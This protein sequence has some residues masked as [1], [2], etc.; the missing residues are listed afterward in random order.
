[1]RCSGGRLARPC[2]LIASALLTLSPGRL[3]AQRA[4]SPALVEL[5]SDS[6]IASYLREIFLARLRR[7]RERSRCEESPIVN[8]DSSAPE[9]RGA[10]LRGRVHSPSNGSGEGI[11]GAQ[12]SVAPLNLGSSTDANGS[13]ELRV[14]PEALAV[15][16]SVTVVARHIGYMAVSIPLVLRRGMVVKLDL[17]LCFQQTHLYEAVVSPSPYEGRSV[18]NDQVSGVDE[19]GIVK[20]H[21]DHLVI[22]HRGRIFT[23]DVSRGHLRRVDM[24]SAPGPGISGRD[25]WYDELL[26]SGDKVV[27]IGYSYRRGGVEIGV[28]S[29]SDSGKLQYLD[30]YNLRSNDYYSSRN[31]SSRLIGS[32]LVIYSPLY[33]TADTAH[34]LEML[35]SMRRWRPDAVLVD[36]GSRVEGEFHPVA[37]ELHT[38]KPAGHVDLSSLQALHSVTTCD[39]AAPEL[40]CE[41]S[42]FVGS[43]ARSLYVSRDAMY[44]ATTVRFAAAAAKDSVPARAVP[45]SLLYRMPLDDRPPT[46]LLI[47]GVPID[48]FSFLERDGELDVLLRARGYGDAMWAPEWPGDGE[49]ALLRLPLARFTDG[50]SEAPRDA[51]MP[52]PEPMSTRPLLDRFVSGHLLYG[53]GSS[54]TPPDTVGSTLF[55]VA[56]STGK[57]TRFDLPYGI[58]RVDALGCDAVVI[59]SDTADL[60]I[61]AVRLGGLPALAQRY[62]VHGASEGETRSH[63]FY[64]RPDDD[65]TDAGTFGLPVAGAGRGGD[66]SLDEYSS[67]LLFVRNEGGAF[68]PL[69]KLE[70]NADRDEDD[71]C[72]AS[73]VDWYGNARPLFVDDRIFALLGYELVEGELRGGSIVEKRRIS[74]AA[75]DRSRS[76][77]PF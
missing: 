53:D 17:P 34:P 28:Y 45:A 32:R 48:Q 66:K 26:V 41:S 39:L 50:T 47:A 36:A 23:V 55:V 60:R 75:R 13:F 44:L 62:T 8:I 30:T 58:S 64:Y 29:I 19:G 18:T 16:D 71:A 21:G 24:A 20:R 25:T 68:R 57:T 11:G 7:E 56:L 76:P 70:A 65:A 51:Y 14:Q 49:L 52:L 33:F 54:W 77:Q 2:A 69:G 46:A 61:T 42:L 74:F 43:D 63:G 73:C 15:A 38:Y 27:V 59:G 9:S 5:R 37:M 67:A 3:P 40:T 12:V 4:G 35:P 1:M 72:E 31:Y 6:E 22:L 10:V